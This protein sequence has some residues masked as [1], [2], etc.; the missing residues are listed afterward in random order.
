VGFFYQKIILHVL[1]VI[2]YVGLRY[3]Q[4]LL[5]PSKDQKDIFCKKSIQILIRDIDNLT[6]FFTIFNIQIKFNAI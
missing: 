4:I 5:P 6:L 1:C 2:E 3:K